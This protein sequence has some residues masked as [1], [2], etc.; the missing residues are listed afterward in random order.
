MASLGYPADDLPIDLCIDNI[1]V[2]ISN[3]SFFFVGTASPAASFILFLITAGRDI[4]YEEADDSAGK[5]FYHLQ[6]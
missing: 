6:V 1:R 4:A 5:K 3:D 2:S